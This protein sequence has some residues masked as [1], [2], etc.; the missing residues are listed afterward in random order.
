M[1]RTNIGLMNIWARVRDLRMGTTG[2]GY[3]VTIATNGVDRLT[4]SDNGI[5]LGVLGNTFAGFN[6]AATATVADGGAVVHGSGAEPS[7]I[8]AIGTVAGEIVSVTAKNSTY[9][10]VAIK[11]NTGATG[12]TQ[13][14]YWIALR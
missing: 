14:I 13:T 10:T 11:T 2:P 7:A 4:V 8:I 3:L 12:T 9:F 5:N 6:W 1:S